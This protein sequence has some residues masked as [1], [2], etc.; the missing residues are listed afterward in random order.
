MLTVTVP[1]RAIIGLQ[2]QP[3]AA[4]IQDLLARIPTD[5]KMSELTDRK[6]KRHSGM[7]ALLYCSGKS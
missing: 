6:H 2:E 1:A 7:A 5:V 4:H 3:L